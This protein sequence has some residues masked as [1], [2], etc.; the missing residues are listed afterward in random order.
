MTHALQM[1]PVRKIA[2]A[3]AL[4]IALLGAAVAVTL[5][6][7]D[8]ALD[9][10]HRVSDARVEEQ[11]AQQAVTIFWH[12]RE[13]MNEYLLAPEA[14]IADEVAELSAEFQRVTRD[15]GSD[16][17]EERVLVERSRAANQAFVATFVRNRGAGGTTSKRELAVIEQLNAGEDAVLAPLDEFQRLSAEDVATASSASH[18]AARQALLVALLAGFLSIL[19]AVVLAVYVVRLIAKL[20]TS[21][22]S[23]AAVLGASVLELRASTK[24]AAAAASEQSSAVAE[25]SATI[26]QLAA[27]ASAIADNARGIAFDEHLETLLARRTEISLVLFDLDDFK[28]INDRDGHPEGDRVLQD[29]SRVVLRELRLGEELFRVGGEEFAIVVSGCEDAGPS[30]AERVRAAVESQWRGSRLTTLSAGVAAASS[31]GT[32]KDELVKQADLALYSAKRA[33]KNRVAAA[34]A[35]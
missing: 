24:E 4:M 16:S 7:Y 6:R 20:V 31:N 32:T 22:H 2:A 10:A 5:W 13:A 12:E 26:E 14:E 29:V 23:T 27:T 21:L 8:H 19:L 3:S 30:V 17:S 34:D 9:E 35:A 18:D 11:S 1:A 33:G 15:V 28:Q 25:T